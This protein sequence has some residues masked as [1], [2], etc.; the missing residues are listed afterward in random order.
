MLIYCAASARNAYA[1]SWLLASCC[2]SLLR[3]R[4]LCMSVMYVFC[5]QAVCL[6]ACL[7]ARLV[8]ARQ[9]NEKRYTRCE[10]WLLSHSSG[11]SVW[12][13]T[14]LAATRVC[15]LTS[16]LLTMLCLLGIHDALLVSLVNWLLGSR[17]NSVL[18]KDLSVWY[19][20]WCKAR[21]RMSAHND[22]DDDD[23]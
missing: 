1:E 22:D 18:W 21:S 10:R 17:L 16:F 3:C 8:A 20:F 12:S 2:W 11:Q 6:I 19:W 15:E 13:W 14:W 7:L 5:V 9:N 23:D 4:P